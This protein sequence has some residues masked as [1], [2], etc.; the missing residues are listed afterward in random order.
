MYKTYYCKDIDTTSGITLTSYQIGNE[1]YVRNIISICQ[2]DNTDDDV[3][4]GN[5]YLYIE[6]AKNLISCLQEAIDSLPK[7]K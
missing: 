2:N 1:L 5:L 7:E 4:P 6:T 3:T